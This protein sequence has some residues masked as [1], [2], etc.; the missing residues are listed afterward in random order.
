MLT[1]SA[2]DD[3]FDATSNDQPATVDAAT[4]AEMVEMEDYFRELS[5]RRQSLD[6]AAAVA[7]EQAGQ[8]MISRSRKRAIRFSDQADVGAVVAV[9]SRRKALSGRMMRRAYHFYGTVT[10]V[11]RSMYAS[12]MF[13]PVH[14]LRVRDRAVGYPA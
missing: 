1:A 9:Y 5:E 3:D 12:R 6:I 14:H 4:S 11:R 7:I 10:S 8:R 13:H 2:S